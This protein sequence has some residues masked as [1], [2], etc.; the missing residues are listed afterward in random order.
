MVKIKQPK[1]IKIEGNIT[2][3]ESDFDEN[4]TKRVVSKETRKKL[5]EKRKQL[6]KQPREGQSKKAQN[7]HSQLI[8]DYITQDSARGRFES[9]RSNEVD[10]YLYQDVV[11]EE[12]E[13]EE[14]QIETYE[15]EEEKPFRTHFTYTKKDKN[16]IQKWLNKKKKELQAL[17]MKDGIMNE[18]DIQKVNF[19][20][21]KMTESLLVNIENNSDNI[22]FED[23][24][25]TNELSYKVD[26]ESQN[27]LIDYLV[28]NNASNFDIFESN[29]LFELQNLLET[30]ELNEDEIEKIKS[31]YR[32]ILP[33]IYDLYTFEVEL[34]IN[35]DLSKEI[36]KLNELF[37]YN[38]LLYERTKYI[39]LIK[40][41]IKDNFTYI[42]ESKLNL[43]FLKGVISNDK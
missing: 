38:F 35:K 18:Y 28:N 5:S 8:K 40:E 43:I 4:K 39:S 24:E 3:Y 37:V 32:K 23:I 20:Q 33:K 21:I 34:R 17:S 27:E 31:K 12:V 42:K 16:I 25:L 15:Q 41:Y 36:D 11:L 30:Y 6:K 10:E 29:Q 19:S 9:N 7:F 14:D 2:Y 13:L 22:D 26:K 1:I